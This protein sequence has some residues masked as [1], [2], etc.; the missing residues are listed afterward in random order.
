M[1]YGENPAD[2]YRSGDPSQL[3]ALEI[4]LSRCSWCLSAELAADEDPHFET[5]ES[6]VIEIPL[7][8]SRERN[9]HD[10]IQRVL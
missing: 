8:W 1:K 3:S 10:M 5:E 9:V 4:A 7:L 2:L 6:E